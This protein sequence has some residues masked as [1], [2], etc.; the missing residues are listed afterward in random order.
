MCQMRHIF[1]SSLIW[2]QRYKIYSFISPKLPTQDKPKFQEPDNNGNL[3]TWKA[4]ADNVNEGYPVFGSKHVV[5]CPNVTDVTIRN[6]RT[7]SGDEVSVGWIEKGNSSQWQIRYRRHDVENA[8]YSYFNTTS[9]PVAIQGIPLGYVYEFSV[10]AV[11]EG[12]NKS[13]WSETQ[14][15]PTAMSLSP[16]QKVLH[17]WL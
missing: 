12:N 9:N 2:S 17:G 7:G 14:F 4:D 10:R 11:G 16:R 15:M 6:V 1:H 8:P 13:G 3:N 5:Q